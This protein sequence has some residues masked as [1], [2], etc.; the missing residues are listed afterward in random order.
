M[1]EG[2]RKTTK[3]HNKDNLLQTEILT[4]HILYMTQNALLLDGE[5]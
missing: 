2:L 3:G 1:P 5:A 4:Q